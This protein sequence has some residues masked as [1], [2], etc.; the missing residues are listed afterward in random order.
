MAEK[1]IEAARAA[2]IISEKL[3]LDLSGLVDIMAEIPA[4]DVQEVRHGR[5]LRENAR[6]RSSIFLCSVC[7][8]KAYFIVGNHK[9][10]PPASISYK[11]CPNCG[12]RMDGEENDRE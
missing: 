3:K 7:K 1:Y 8:A 2:E 5:W 4:A 9:R 11:F 10:T 6:P 12:A